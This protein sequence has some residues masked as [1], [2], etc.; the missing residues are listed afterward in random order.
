MLATSAGVRIT[1]LATPSAITSAAAPTTAG[2][3]IDVPLS[4]V[5][6]CPGASERMFSPGATMTKYFIFSLSAQVAVAAMQASPGRVENDEIWLLA[7]TL[8][9]IN[10]LA[11][12]VLALPA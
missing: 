3:A 4:V 8:P 12:A 5:V 9:T 1:F 10:R 7:L 2:V 11:R 6:V